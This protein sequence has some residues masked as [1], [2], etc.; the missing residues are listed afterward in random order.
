MMLL[1]SDFRGIESPIEHLYSFKKAEQ[2]NLAWT[3]SDLKSF[4]D[5][6]KEMP[7]QFD[8]LGETLKWMTRKEKESLRRNAATS[9]LSHMDLSDKKLSRALSTK[10][11]ARNDAISQSLFQKEYRHVSSKE[12]KSLNEYLLK[13]IYVLRTNLPLNFVELIHFVLE[14][15]RLHLVDRSNILQVFELFDLD[16]NLLAEEYI[17]AEMPLV[18]DSTCQLSNIAWSV[19][20]YPHELQEMCETVLGP[21]STLFNDVSL[22]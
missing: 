11:T 4:S 10:V 2:R 16:P 20:M 14:H 12:L 5:F 7:L 9:A 13:S 17:M 6:I 15:P 19:K 1:S 8:P 21:G 22:D 3:S 18:S